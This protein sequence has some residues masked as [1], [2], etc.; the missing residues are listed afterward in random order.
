MDDIELARHGDA[1]ALG[2]LVVAHQE[3]VGRLMWRFTRDRLEWESLVQDTFVEMIGSIRGFRADSDLERWLARIATRVGYRHWTRRRRSRE[4][5]RP[6]PEAALRSLAARPGPAEAA[7]L[8]HELL[9]RIEPPERLAL[10]L[11]YLEGLSLDDAAS[12]AGWSQGGMK[13]RLRRARQ[14]LEREARDCGIEPGDLP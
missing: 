2:R 6:L 12:R 1:A 8:L 9:D 5:E 4:Q 7:Q 3:F 10:T 13:M 14:R 11:V